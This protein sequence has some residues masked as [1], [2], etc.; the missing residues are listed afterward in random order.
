MTK[1]SK[2]SDN[3]ND[4]KIYAS[5]TWMSGNDESS[6]IDF[7]DSSQFTNWVLDS[8]ATCHMTPQVSDFIPGSLENTDKYIEVADGNHVTTKQKGKVQIKMWNNNRYTFIAKF[9]NVL[10]APDL[11]DKLFSI[12]RLMNLGNICLFYK[13]FFMV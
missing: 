5:M 6:S 10:L 3:D 12:I 4:E 13:G 1:K 7:S 8:G 2:N 11:Y 9:H